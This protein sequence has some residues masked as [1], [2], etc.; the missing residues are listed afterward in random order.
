MLEQ[1]STSNRQRLQLL[2]ISLRIS[3]KDLGMESYKFQLVHVL[4]PRGRLAAAI[5]PRSLIISSAAEKYNCFAYTPQSLNKVI[6]GVVHEIEGQT[7]EIV[8][9]KGQIEWG[10]VKPVAKAIWPM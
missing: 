5:W 7:T 6:G 3:H 2:H 9:K 1:S 4:M 10:Y 8:L